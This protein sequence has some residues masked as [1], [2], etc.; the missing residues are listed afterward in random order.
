MAL[1]PQSGLRPAKAYNRKDTKIVDEYL[2][3]GKEADVCQRPLSNYGVGMSI[4]VTF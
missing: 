2:I 1:I 4:M 3:N